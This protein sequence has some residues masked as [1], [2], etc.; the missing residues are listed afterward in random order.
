MSSAAAEFRY[1][2]GTA[3]YEGD[4][5]AVYETEYDG[6][7]AILKFFRPETA[8]D[9]AKLA[10]QLNSASRLRHSHL[11]RIYDSGETELF[12]TH[13]VFVVMERGDDTL[14]GGGVLSDQDK[15]HV[16]DAIQSAL[17]FLRAQGHAH[18]R[19]KPSN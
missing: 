13:V 3:L 6:S 12:E 7:P 1:T 10:A 4:S 15:A 16:H 14:T 19:V 5:Q 18:G 17:D 9:A 11:T 8:V 2:L